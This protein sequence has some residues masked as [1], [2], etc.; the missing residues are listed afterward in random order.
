MDVTPL[1]G[2][3]WDGTGSQLLHRG[4]CSVVS[5]CLQP[6]VASVQCKG[7]ET[8]AGGGNCRTDAIQAA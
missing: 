6:S 1:P 8:Q 5:I 4:I 7:S 3:P 2:V